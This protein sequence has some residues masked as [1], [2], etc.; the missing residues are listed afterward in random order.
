GAVDPFFARH[1]AAWA[2]TSYLGGTRRDPRSGMT[3][4]ISSHVRKLGDLFTLPPSLLRVADWKARASGDPQLHVDEALNDQ[5]V[6][7]DLLDDEFKRQHDAAEVDAAAVDNLDGALDLTLGHNADRTAPPDALPDLPP[8]SSGYVYTVAASAA[9]PAE[10]VLEDWWFERC[11]AGDRPPERAAPLGESELDV[12]TIVGEELLSPELLR[13]SESNTSVSL[14]REEAEPVAARMEGAVDADAEAEA[15][16][17]LRTRRLKARE[18]REKN[19]LCAQ[20]S[21]RRAKAV[22]DGLKADLR[23]CREKLEVLRAKE[24]AL[25]Q[26][27]LELRRSFAEPLANR[28]DVSSSYV[29]VRNELIKRSAVF[30]AWTST[31]H[32]QLYCEAGEQGRCV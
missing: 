25:R 8:I 4:I 2:A 21:N 31:F 12:S 26:M 32:C 19:R 5:R 14:F 30:K 16:E 18:R 11:E 23:S 22:R 24:M 17:K 27:N 9:A 3:P 10:E 6:L 28:K 13:S 29:Q 20:R 7:Q 1:I 15:E